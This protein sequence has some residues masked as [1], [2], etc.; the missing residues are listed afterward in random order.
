LEDGGEDAI[1]SKGAVDLD[2][3]DR[4]AARARA[5]ARRE[6]LERDGGQ[7]VR[8]RYRSSNSIEGREVEIRGDE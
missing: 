8:E 2:A 7:T 5:R 1:A 6:G 3:D 4:I